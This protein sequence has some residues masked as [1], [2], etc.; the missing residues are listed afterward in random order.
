[1]AAFISVSRDE[2]AQR[3]RTI[4]AI[5]RALGVGFDRRGDSIELRDRPIVFKTYTASIAGVEGFTAICVIGDELAKW[6]DHETGANPA[7]E[8]V[9]SVRPTV[10]TQPTARI[11]LSSSA[12]S[13]V[14]FHYDTFERG[15]AAHQC[16]A[17]ATTWEANPTIGEADTH[18]LEPDDRVWAREYNNIPQSAISAAYELAV[19]DRAF[20]PRDP[21]GC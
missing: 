4:E 11:F 19:L 7:R 21:P 5:L 17:A 10:A 16:V 8:V 1:M 14:D 9:A 2:S 15:D 13:T 18:G 3:L 6:R 12:F 20:R